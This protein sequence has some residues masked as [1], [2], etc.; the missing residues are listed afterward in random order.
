MQTSPPTQCVLST[1]HVASPGTH[2]SVSTS[3]VLPMGHVQFVVVMFSRTLDH[4]R[5]T[6]IT[7]RFCIT[8]CLFVCFFLLVERKSQSLGSSVF[9]L[10]VAVLPC[11]WL[12]P[13]R[14]IKRIPLNTLLNV[15]SSSVVVLQLGQEGS[16]GHSGVEQNSGLRGEVLITVSGFGWLWH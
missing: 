13:V 16:G 5:H 1:S 15:P 10:F 4:T 3:D 6:G 7:D 12:F 11:F 2:S 9:L 14:A 8:F